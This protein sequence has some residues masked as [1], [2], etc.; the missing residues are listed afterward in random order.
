MI[1]I[2]LLYI[3]T[4]FYIGEKRVWSQ[5]SNGKRHFFY[6]HNVKKFSEFFDIQKSKLG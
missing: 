6:N 1:G 5:I 4:L 2:F 3:F